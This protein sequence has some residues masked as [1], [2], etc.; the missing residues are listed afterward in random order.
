[1]SENHAEHVVEIVR[2]SARQP[3]WVEPLTLLQAG[4]QIAILL[5]ARLLAVMSTC[6]DDG[7]AAECATAWRPWG[8]SRASRRVAAVLVKEVVLPAVEHART[9][10]RITWASAAPPRCSRGTPRGS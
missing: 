4:L 2:D 6:D 8:T 3:P 1:M 5:F 10:S 9:P 7:A